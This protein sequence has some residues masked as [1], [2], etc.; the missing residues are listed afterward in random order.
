M[1]GVPGMFPQS[2]SIFGC[3]ELLQLQCMPRISLGS[4][5]VAELL[6]LRGTLKFG[7]GMVALQ[8]E[9]C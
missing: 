3:T 8:S 5:S 2:F 6:D 9:G 4:R 7:F 1:L